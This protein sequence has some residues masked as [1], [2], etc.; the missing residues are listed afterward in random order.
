MIFHYKVGGDKP[1]QVL[2]AAIKVKHPPATATGEMVMMILSGQF[3]ALGFTRNLDGDQPAL[4]GEA[5]DR[6]VYRGDA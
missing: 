4:L 5:A 6:A 2:G 3:V 1:S